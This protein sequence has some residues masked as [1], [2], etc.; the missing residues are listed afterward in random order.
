MRTFHVGGTATAG[1]QV[2]KT[3]AKTAGI[4]KFENVKTFTR[5][6][7]STIIM[8]K[9][10]EI[11]VMTD[12]GVEKERYG[13][14]YGATIFFKNGDEVNVGDKIL[15]WDPFAMPLISEVRG[16]VKFEDLVVGGTVRE[17]T[18]PVTGLAHKVVIEA[19]T[20]EDASKQPRIVIVDENGEPIIVQGT[21]RQAVYRLPVGSHLTVNEGDQ[22]DGGI[23]IAKVQRE[24]TKTKDITGGLPRVAELFEAR[25]P[26]NAAQLA[27]MNGTIEYGP[28]VRGSR[29]ILIKPEDGGDPAVMVVPKGRF[30]TVNE[31][32]Y[33]R[34][35]DQIMDGAPNPHDILNVLGEKELAAYIVTEI[36]EVYRLQGV[37]IDDKHIEVIVSQMLKK[38]EITSPGDSLFVEGDSITRSTLEEENERLVAD[39]MEPATARPLLLGITKASLT[40]DSFLSAASFQETTKVLTQ[41][42]LEGK[43]DYLRGLKENVLMGRLIP[44]G[45]GIPKY[46]EYVAQV[47]KPED[48]ISL[49]M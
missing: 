36:Q 28:E 4:I 39:G 33:V 14:Q 46:K 41:A 8:N 49:T 32:D 15:E 29:R 18:D 27:P 30:I 38:V 12:Q 5:E 40:T 21:K 6:D 19:K 47:E 7:G 9:T 25:K 20:K 13:A 23:V 45:T 34:L 44:A 43:K 24:S 22:V 42:A 48:H 17:E 26:S 31:G 2:N 1:A 16:T 37:K 11:V 35:G 10:G 3:E